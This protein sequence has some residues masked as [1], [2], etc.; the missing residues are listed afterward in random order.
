MLTMPRMSLAFNHPYYT[1]RQQKDIVHQQKQ[2][3]RIKHTTIESQTETVISN[4][5]PEPEPETTT[6]LQTSTVLVKNN[7]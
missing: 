7:V 1:Y 2:T 6:P 4:P 5:K 3:K